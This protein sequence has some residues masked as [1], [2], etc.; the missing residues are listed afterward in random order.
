MRLK[1]V[2]INH[3]YG[4]M[5]LGLMELDSPCVIVISDGKARLAKLPDH[6]ETRVVTH[7]GKVKRVKFD[8]G[9]EF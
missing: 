2:E 3:Q 9:E 8:E 7:Q 1:N 6:G 4:E 5:D